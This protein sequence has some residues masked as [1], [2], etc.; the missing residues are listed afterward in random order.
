MQRGAFSIP[1]ALAILITSCSKDD[2]QIHLEDYAAIS[3]GGIHS[4]FLDMNGPLWG[5]GADTYGQFIDGEFGEW[6]FGWSPL[7]IGHDYT[8]ICEGERFSLGHY[9]RKSLYC[10]PLHFLRG[11]WQ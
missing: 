4:L 8:S 6:T 9:Q 7:L 2:I 5:T 11:Q 10:K 3:A 1:F